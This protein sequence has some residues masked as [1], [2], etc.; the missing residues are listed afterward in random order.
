M[1]CIFCRAEQSARPFPPLIICN[2]VRFQLPITQLIPALPAILPQIGIIPFRFFCTP[3]PYRPI[4]DWLAPGYVVL[5]QSTVGGLSLS[6]SE[7]STYAR[8]NARLNR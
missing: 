8:F 2:Y 5:P 1:K 4:Y 7:Q 3:W 6:N